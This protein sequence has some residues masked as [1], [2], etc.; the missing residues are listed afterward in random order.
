MSTNIVNPEVEM[1]L[2]KQKAQSTVLSVVIALLVVILVGV[3]L[4]FQLIKINQFVEPDITAVSIPSLKE[5]VSEK[6]KTTSSVKKKPSSP[7]QAANRVIVSS[8]PSSLSVV[9][10]KN[11]SPV[12]S[13]EFGSGTG[14]GSGF[15]GGGGG[16]GGGSS[17][18]G[19][20]SKANRVAFVI[21]YSASMRQN[22]RVGLMKEELDRSLDT[23]SAGMK[24]QM[25]FF[26]GP[27]W[28]A[29]SDV[30]YRGS[31][32]EAKTGN[33]ITGPDEKE[34]KWKTKGGANGFEPVG[35]MQKANWITVNSTH[36]K[37]GAQRRDA[38]KAGQKTIAESKEI[39]RDTKLVWGTRWKYALEMAL[40]MEPTPE[41]IYFM[42]DGSTGREAGEV[43]RDVARKAKRAGCVVNCI[44]MMEPRA[45]DAMKE[46][47]K[48][49]GGQFT[50]VKAGGEVEEVDLN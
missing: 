44:A 5:T 47:A 35:K 18:F 24:Y 19:A 9:N 21:D 41:V 46:I 39:V 12:K 32:Q 6:K 16:N 31:D 26:A 30:A 29:G 48:K 13:L 14:I 2:K 11:V 20:T 50:I 8:A 34:Y 36:G 33:I 40:E 1:L 42:T 15:G 37:L 7:S 49:T 23:L 28:V 4:V 17:F 25:I 22:N 45:H 27:V 38:E 10:P 43:A 3:I